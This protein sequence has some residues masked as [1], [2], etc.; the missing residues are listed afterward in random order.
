M[1]KQV[2]AGVGVMVLNNEGEV[3]LG[4]RHSD[5]KKADSKL[6]GAGTWTMPGGKL[7]FGEE[8]EGCAVREL[9]EETGIIA[10]E[11]TV[12]CVCNTKDHNAHFVTVGLLCS[13]YNGE[14]QVCEPDTIVE[15]EWF[16]I[17]AL[18]DPMYFPSEH[19]IACYNQDTHYVKK[20]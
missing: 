3:L 10:N 13:D 12:L 14:P 15:W 8:F 17:D 20:Y 4:R 18:P 6:S 7:E 1:A 11:L 5:P 9:E 19:I 16:S 2:G